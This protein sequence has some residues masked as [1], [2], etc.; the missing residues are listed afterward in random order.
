MRYYGLELLGDLGKD[1]IVGI[2]GPYGFAAFAVIDAISILKN[3]EDAVAW[4]AHTVDDN[5]Y[6]KWYQSQ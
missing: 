4:L 5:V 2:T 1:T 3:G 6:E